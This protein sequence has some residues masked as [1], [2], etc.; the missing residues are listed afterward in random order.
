[1]KIYQ[2]KKYEKLSY[3]QLLCYN[4]WGHNKELIL[5]LF[6]KAIDDEA[7]KKY[8]LNIQK[9]ETQE[10]CDSLYQVFNEN[11]NKYKYLLADKDICEHAKFL[12]EKS[13]TKGFFTRLFNKLSEINVG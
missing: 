2:A 9:M 13:R 1:M 6:D 10:D 5:A 12:V 3:K 4:S 8:F 7:R 11:D